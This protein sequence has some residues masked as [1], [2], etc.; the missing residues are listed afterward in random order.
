MDSGYQPS[1]NKKRINELVILYEL[2][3]VLLP[4]TSPKVI[5]G[6]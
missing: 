6:D 2:D 4:N 5:D 3:D 1:T